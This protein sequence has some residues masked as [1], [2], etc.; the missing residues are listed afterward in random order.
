[1]DHRLPARDA[2]QE[3][4]QGLKRRQL[5]IRIENI[6]LGLIG[7]KRRRSILADDLFTIGIRA[8]CVADFALRGQR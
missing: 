8:A 1:M 3:V 4:S 5:L 2:A 7:R 6:E